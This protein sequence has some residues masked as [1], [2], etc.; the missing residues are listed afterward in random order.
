LDDP[1]AQSRPDAMPFIRFSIQDRLPM[2]PAAAQSILGALA[3]IA[4]TAPAAWLALEQGPVWVLVPIGVVFIGLWGVRR[5]V[6]LIADD[7]PAAVPLPPAQGPVELQYGDEEE[8]RD[9]GAAPSHVDRTPPPRPPL[10]MVPLAGGKFLMGSDPSS[11]AHSSQDESPRHEVRLDA[12]RIGRS[13]VTRGQWRTVMAS[14]AEPWRREVPARWGDGDDQLPAT[15]LDW[16]DAL[17]FCNALSLAEGATPCYAWA[18]GR[19]TCDW[20]ADGYR[21]PTEAEWEYAC[22]GGRETPWFWGEGA[23]DADR[24]A[25]Y[26]ANSVGEL[27]PVGTRE[28]NN[29][30]LRDMAGNCWEWCW[31]WY[32]EYGGRA[33][34][35]PRGPA[36]GRDRVLRGGS[37][38]REP[39]FLRSAFRSWHE[40]GNRSGFIGFRCV[41]SGAPALDNSTP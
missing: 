18:G 2:L 25:W 4:C 16:F 40:P 13:L 21:L 27:R 35:N 28:P 30:G 12:F 3:G 20:S 29:F 17:A 37:F 33:A 14:A 32:G 19:W 24:F 34:R 31:D 26:S 1:N 41:R 9:E 39:W 6:G 23:S 7:W 38:G 8:D 22:R 15:D 36:E 5:C 11:D 10:D